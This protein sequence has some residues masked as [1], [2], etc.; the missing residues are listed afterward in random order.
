MEGNLMSEEMTGIELI[1]EKGNLISKDSFIKKMENVYDE[2]ALENQNECSFLDDLIENPINTEELVET[3]N[4]INRTIY[5]GDVTQE[6]ANCVQ[7]MIYLWNELDEIE[8]VPIDERI[9]IKVII[10]SPGGDLN[11]SFTIIDAIELSK[12]PVHTYTIGMGYS[13][14]F[15]I[16]I[17]GHKRFGYPHSSYCFHEGAAQDGGDAHKFIQRVDFYKKQLKILKKITIEHT[18]ISEEEYEKRYKDDWFMTAEEALEMGVIDEISK[19]MFT[20]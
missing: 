6:I 18:L 16:G 19:E 3:N 5:I 20:I 15:F 10:N 7:E 4:F 2:I 11:A 12:T 17:C 13:G 14:G 1:D 9:V 8:D